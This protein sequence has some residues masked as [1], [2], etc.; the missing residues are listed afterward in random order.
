VPLFQYKAAAADGQV[1]EGQMEA[2]NRDA[3]VRRLQSQG[4]VPIRAEEVGL[5]ARRSAGVPGL[6]RLRRVGAREV[7]FFTTET[8]TLLQAGLPLD[9]VLELLEGLSPEASPMRPVIAGLQSRVRGGADLSAALEEHPSLFSPFYVNMVRAGEAG[10][11][12]DASMAR[13]A[14]F[15]ER[16]RAVRDAIG[17]AMV[18]PAILLSVAIISLSVILS[19]VVPS[20]SQMFQD[21][22]EQLPWYTRF[23]VASGALVENY[24]WLMLAVAVGAALWWRQDYATSQGR[25]RWDTLALRLPLVGELTAKTEAAR[26]ARSLGN[27]LGNGVPLLDAVAISRDIVSNAVISRG[28]ERVAVSI[29]E[30][31]GLSTPLLRE[32][33]VPEMAAKLVRV[34][35]ESGQ[36]EEMLLKVAQIYEQEVDSSIKRLVSVLAPALVLVLA[37]L[38]LGI[39]VSLVV[40]II[41]LNQLT[42]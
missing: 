27:M 5:A 33:V 17:Q 31:E 13:L 38:I 2:D 1:L 20:I 32:R 12:L 35:E 6:S 39:M 9:R 42:F 16:S 41:T 29:R 10:G 22:G 15:L 26:L 21:A 40:P 37:A 14:D 34:G 28:I 19:V 4:H 23:V 25:M 24:W 3:V 7:Q 30:G 11:A 36:L 8:A 18:Y